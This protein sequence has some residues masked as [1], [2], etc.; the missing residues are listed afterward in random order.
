MPRESKEAKA[1]RAIAER[2]VAVLK[3][4]ATGIA[5]HF[6]SSEPDPETLQP[7]VYLVAVYLDARQVVRECTCANAQAHPIRPRCC[8]V[9]LAERLWR[10]DEQA[11]RAHA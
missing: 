1:L 11:S 9:W 10:P 8:H 3:V 6:T 4:S 5:L 7:R 2:R